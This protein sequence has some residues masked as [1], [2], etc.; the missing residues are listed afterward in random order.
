MTVETFSLTG[1]AQTFTWPSGVESAEADIRAGQGGS[2]SNSGGWGGKVT[3]A[4]TKGAEATLQI[5]VGRGGEPKNPWNGGGTTTLC[6]NSTPGG[7]GGD[8][9]DIRQGGTALADRIGIAGGGGGGA[10]NLVDELPGG[11]GGAGA[12]TTGTAGGGGYPAGG[13]SP[14]GGGGGTPSAGGAGGAAGPNIY[15][16]VAGTAGSLGQG[17]T[18]GGKTNIGNPSIAGGG[19]G[20]GGGLYGGGGGQMGSSQGG[21][22]GAGGGGGSCYTGGLANSP[23]I[24]SHGASNGVITLTYTLPATL[25]QAI[26]IA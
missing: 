7:Y 24:T 2:G 13:S 25:Q 3:G 14:A 26:I 19:G 11:S 17:G 18:G 16:G 22:S 4:V 20:G 23:V 5:N 21:G 10:G 1:S 8:A 6:Y 12:G 15:V 9:S